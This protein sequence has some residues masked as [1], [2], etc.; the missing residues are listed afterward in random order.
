[1]DNRQKRELTTVIFDYGCVISLP[2]DEECVKRM[3]TLA[4]LSPEEF[5]RNYRS[6]RADYDRGALTAEEYW[7]KVTGDRGNN[8]SQEKLNRLIKED[9]KSW[10]RTNPAVIEWALKLKKEGKRLALLSNMPEDCAE[11][12]REEFSDWLSRFDIIVF[13]YEIGI[14]KPEPGIFKYCLDLLGEAPKN[15]LFIDDTEK[16]I[17]TARELGM[18]GIVF[19]DLTSITE[20]A[21]KIYNLP[22]VIEISSITSGRTDSI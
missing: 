20:P 2:Q 22:P 6:F 19:K 18:D 9:I 12:I 16:N 11:Y 17:T 8:L 21:V 4:G 5:K 15:C 3:Y 7:V 13:S 10:T 1:M 14:N